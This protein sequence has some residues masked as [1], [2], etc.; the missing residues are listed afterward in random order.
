MGFGNGIRDDYTS[1][2]RRLHVNMARKR[3]SKCDYDAE[4]SR[5][6]RQM[7]GPMAAVS[8]VAR[9]SAV[10]TM[11]MVD[12]TICKGMSRRQADNSHMIETT[13]PLKGDSSHV[14]HKN[15]YGLGIIRDSLSVPLPQNARSTL[16]KVTAILFWTT[17]SSNKNSLMTGIFR[18]LDSG[19][20]LIDKVTSCALRLFC[21]TRR[22][23]WGLFVNKSPPF[24]KAHEALL[25]LSQDRHICL[26]ETT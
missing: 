16:G 11:R 5:Y 21:K 22:I 9:K 18:G 26:D 19:R 17:R 4:T 14:K 24:L 10:E 23:R 8:T 15:S 12:S 3:H 6:T 20:F 1:R 7:R 13:V 25:H 2:W